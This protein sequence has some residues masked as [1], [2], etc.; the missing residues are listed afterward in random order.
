MEANTIMNDL[1]DFAQR[2]AND[3]RLGLNPGEIEL[4][5][6]FN[7]A[8]EE[9]LAADVAMSFAVKNGFPVDGELI[10]EFMRFG[11]P[12]RVVGVLRRGNPASSFAS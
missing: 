7:D 6:E 12:K 4:V 11:D 9:W 10:D 3:V 2:L 5:D 8:G 1:V